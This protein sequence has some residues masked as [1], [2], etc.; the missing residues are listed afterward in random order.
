MR[1][2]TCGEES[3]IDWNSFSATQQHVY[4]RTTLKMRQ[5][6]FSTQETILNSQNVHQLHVHILVVFS[7]FVLFSDPLSAFEM[8]ARGSPHGLM[9]CVCVCVCDLVKMV[10]R[11]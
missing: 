4:F 9:S 6:L 5:E 8:A 3:K 2:C 10:E 7:F 1:V 11:V